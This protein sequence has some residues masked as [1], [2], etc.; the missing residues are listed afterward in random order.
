MVGSQL[1]CTFFSYENFLFDESL[2]KIIL[3]DKERKINQQVVIVGDVDLTNILLTYRFISLIWDLIREHSGPPQGAAVPDYLTPG[4]LSK[5][6]LPPSGSTTA[7]V[8]LLTASALSIQKCTNHMDK[9]T[10]KVY[11]SITY[12]RNSSWLRRLQSKIYRHVFKASDLK[13]KILFLLHTCILIKYKVS[14]LWS[15]LHNAK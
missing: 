3:L 13:F 2:V 7:N 5:P 12:L 8:L 1:F 10:K 9:F 4:F 15:M 6:M 11:S 14:V